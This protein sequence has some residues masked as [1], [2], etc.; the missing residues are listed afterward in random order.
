M[1]AEPHVHGKRGAAEV[2]A[3][4][5]REESAAA[6]ASENGSGDEEEGEDESSEEEEKLE[7]K[8]LPK[9]STRGARV[10][11]VHG[12]GDDEFWQQDFFAEGAGDDEPDNDYAKS[13]AEQD[14]E[15]DEVDSDFDEQESDEDDE[16]VQADKEGKA[17]KKK[18]AYVDPKHAAAA[19]KRAAAAKKAVATKAAARKAAAAATS[20]P[21]AAGSAAGAP[22]VAPNQYDDDSGFPA[23]ASAAVIA[24]T[25]AAAPKKRRGAAS[26][27]AAGAGA[28]V[29][30]VAA[31]STLSAAQLALLGGAG[32]KSIR[33]ATMESSIET[34]RKESLDQQRRRTQKPKPKIE[35]RKW[36]Q[37]ELLAESVHT[38]KENTA[39]LE[40]MLRLEEERKKEVA[41]KPVSLGPRIK[42]QSRN[43][44]KE[45][46]SQWIVTFTEGLP[47]YL[48]P[49]E[50]P[51]QPSASAPPLGQFGFHA[52]VDAAEYFADACCSDLCSLF[53]CGACVCVGD[54]C[55]ERS[56][57]CFD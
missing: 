22:A 23:E 52:C 11:E 50:P 38:E 32:R 12:E 54:S 56:E 14:E 13:D 8:I 37:Q 20:A 31:G 29:G 3:A 26:T 53:G 10:T 15:P 46:H 45:D 48:Q 16:E 40:L 1:D 36:T 9:R 43:R 34:S 57:V 33:R 6:A 25:A 27:A 35:F 41:P 51:G 4:A 42:I 17:A 19:A 49:Q 2:E 5:L 24:P 7:P 30:G 28:G 55:S 44:S 47:D 39:S 21:P 18:G